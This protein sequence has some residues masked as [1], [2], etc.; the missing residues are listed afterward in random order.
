MNA[1]DAEG[2]QRT[3]R[4]NHPSASSANPPRPRRSLVS[5]TDAGAWQ[6][7]ATSR[8]AICTAFK[9]APLRS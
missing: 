4:K 8:S 5:L 3:L 2:S 7:Y 6:D 9:A 1:E